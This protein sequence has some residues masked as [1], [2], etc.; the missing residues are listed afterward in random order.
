MRTALVVVGL[1]FVAVAVVL[2]LK[3]SSAIAAQLAEANR[4][5]AVRISQEAAERQRELEEAKRL[6]ALRIAQLEA[7]RNQELA[8]AAGRRAVLRDGF[9]HMKPVDVKVHTDGESFLPEA[10]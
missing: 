10:F 3:E 8:E 7:A 6:E 4:L 5:Q 2:H 9:K 1:L